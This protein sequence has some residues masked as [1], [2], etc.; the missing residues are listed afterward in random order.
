MSHHADDNYNNTFKL[1][2]KSFKEKMNKL[3]RDI[4]ETEDK[5]SEFKQETLS[6]RRRE[7][8][9]KQKMKEIAE[10]I[11]DSED[12]IR[13]IETRIAYQRSRSQEISEKYR[14][15]G[16]VTNTLESSDVDLEKTMRDL[17]ETKQ[18]TMEI[19]RM[20]KG[21]RKVIAA[22]EPKI[23]KAEQREEK[24]VNRSLFIRQ[25]L[26]IHHYLATKTPEGFPLPEED[27]HPQTHHVLKMRAKIKGNIMR[28][29]EAEKKIIAF[30]E[31]I[32]VMTKALENYRR[33]N[34]EFQVTKR[35]L[36]S[37]NFY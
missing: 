37:S 7:Y 24:A 25:K 26:A 19:R 1:N 28:A 27:I 15:N 22:I 13:K 33:R 35:E 11:T 21:L 4:K 29:I 2:I 23:E 3:K 8:V 18:H 34:L 17:Q 20:N 14:E 10:N 32:K 12:K 16:R 9:A 5:I 31:K 30:E 6:A 36:L